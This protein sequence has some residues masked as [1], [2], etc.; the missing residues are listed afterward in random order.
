MNTREAFKIGFLLK[1]A[2]CGLTEEETRRR[3]IN[4][5]VKQQAEETFVK[6]ADPIPGVRA[7]GNILASVAN[8]V[9]TGLKDFLG[10][11]LGMGKTI[12]LVAPPIGGILGGYTLAKMKEDT[13]SREESRQKELAMEYLRS[14]GELKRMRQRQLSSHAKPA[15]GARYGRV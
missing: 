13:T 14:I 6:Q 7:A 1:C 3:A 9:V 15:S 12:Y 5:L 2:E 4:L 10:K 8:P 11:I